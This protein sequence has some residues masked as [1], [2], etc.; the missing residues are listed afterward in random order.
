MSCSAIRQHAAPQC[1]GFRENIRFTAGERKLH[2]RFE[3][4]D[5]EAPTSDEEHAASTESAGPFRPRQYKGGP[6]QCSERCRSPRTNP[7]PGL[8]RH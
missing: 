7:A 4:S 2:C 6:P 8:R 3:G 1:Y 5:G